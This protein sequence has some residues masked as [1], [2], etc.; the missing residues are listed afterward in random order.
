MVEKYITIDLIM[1][2]NYVFS[3]LILS[4]IGFI[5][6][7]RL[8]LLPF[9]YWND[10]RKQVYTRLLANILKYHERPQ[11][12]TS[13]K[14]L[15]VRNFMDRMSL[16]EILIDKLETTENE[17]LK[18]MLTQ[19]YENLGLF[20]WRKKMLGY[21]NVWERRIT[22]DILG[23]SL[24]KKA[25]AP[26]MRISLRDRD[27]DVRF[28]AVKSLG[29]LKAVESIGNIIKLI[30]KLPSE[31][32]AVVADIM[33]NFGLDSVPHIV[34][35]LDSRN[36]NT[37]YW[38]LR[39]LVEIP[40]PADHP[41]MPQIRSKLM[42]LLDDPNPEVRGYSAICLSR[43]G[44]NESVGRI[45]ELLRSDKDPY[46]RSHA[47]LALGTLKD[48]SAIE[49]LVNSLPD[50]NWDVS[51]NASQSLAKFGQK[52]EQIIKNN[53]SCSISLAWARCMEVADE[54]GINE[55]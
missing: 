2:V 46:V 4:L 47:A 16:E 37:K 13:K 31:R 17:R 40:V 23:K 3:L 19:I 50:E 34:K 33:I 27:E 26:L 7:R 6:L 41:D 10:R 30:E 38:C 39:S 44:V 18:N 32:C 28:L 51:F 29:R 22:V 45:R 43:L 35:Q 55:F 5:I 20:E 11:R 1:Q 21:L 9:D 36:A 52:V 15:R 42:S 8:L 48:P 54:V 53:P 25:I 49:D 14:L 24:S 12:F